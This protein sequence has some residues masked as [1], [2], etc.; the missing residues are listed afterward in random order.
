MLRSAAAWRPSC[1]SLTKSNAARAAAAFPALTWE[2]SAASAASGTVRRHH[3]PGPPSPQARVLTPG[4][5][6]RPVRQPV[7]VPRGQPAPV[8]GPAGQPADDDQRDGEGC[9]GGGRGLV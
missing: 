5:P 3:L 2:S 1:S 9:D 4:G 8:Q 7:V 6:A